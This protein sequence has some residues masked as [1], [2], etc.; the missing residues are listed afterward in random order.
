MCAL[1]QDG[2]R[3]IVE[4]N[5]RLNLIENIW[6]QCLEKEL[7]QKIHTACELLHCNINNPG[8]RRHLYAFVTHVTESEKTKLE[9]MSELGAVAALSRL[10]GCG[11]TIK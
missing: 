4:D 7:T 6:T 9:G 3:A 2:L 5:R 1:L 11:G 10:L 8:Y